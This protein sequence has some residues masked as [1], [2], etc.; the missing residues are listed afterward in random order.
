[1]P[2]LIHERKVKAQIGCSRKPFETTVQE[3]RFEKTKG[4]CADH[5]LEF[6][7]QSLQVSASA[8]ASSPAALG[9]RAPV[10]Y[11]KIQTEKIRTCNSNSISDEAKG[12]N[13]HLRSRAEGNPQALHTPFCTWKV[14]RPHRRQGT[15]V[16]LCRL[17]KLAVPLPTTY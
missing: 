12:F 6:A 15:W 13:S 3:N 4:D 16:L 17:P 1:M 14:L 10:V 8:S 2:W 11:R 5:H 7:G 9:L